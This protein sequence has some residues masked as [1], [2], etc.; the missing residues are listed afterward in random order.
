MAAKT[1]WRLPLYVFG[2]VCFGIAAF[3]FVQSWFKGRLPEAAILDI[4]LMQ[5]VNA[6][7]RAA[8]S[9]ISD[10]SYHYDFFSLLDQPVPERTVAEISLPENPAIKAKAR[11]SLNRLTGKY[12]IQVAS[13][14]NAASAQNLVRELNAQGY[15]AVVFDDAVNGST[16]YRVR[17]DGGVK[18]EQAELLQAAIQKRTG[19]KGS[20]VSL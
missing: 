14:K 12:A 8:L 6:Q 15:H 1:S 2:I 10:E 19:L 4:N 9:P 20:L 3:I 17:I 16:L 11:R 7:P 18:K 13:M 5:E